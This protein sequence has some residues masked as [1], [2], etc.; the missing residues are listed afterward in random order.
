MKGFFS[1]F[2]I[3]FTISMILTWSYLYMPQSFF[4][5]DNRLRDFMFIL[6]GEIPQS[7]NVV[8]VDIDEKSLKEFGQWPW[9]RDIFSKLLYNLT[10]AG[11]GIIGLDIVFAEKDRTSP[12]RYAKQFPDL[13]S[14]LPNYDK[15]LGECL[16]QTPVIGGYIFSF[17]KDVKEKDMVEPP[18]IPAI[19]I[20]KGLI[21]NNT[22]LVPSNVIL[23]VDV[24]Q[25]GFFSTGF[26]NTIP[27]E[28][29]MI[30]SVPL[31]MMYDGLVYPSLTLEML[32]A[33]SGIRKVKV[34][35][36]DAGIRSI[37]FG[38]YSIPTDKVGRIIVNYRGKG[39]T[40]KY[41]AAQKILNN[42]FNPEDI[43]G[44]YILIGTS[45][46]GLFDLRSM[47]FDSAYAGVEV[48][49]NVIDNVLTGDYLKKP[50]D[51]IVYDIIIIWI[52]TFFFLMV[53]SVINSWWII[54]TGLIAVYALFEF[55]FH[56]LFTY[57][58]VLNLLLPLVSYSVTLII[59]IGI[60]YVI[61]TR[62]KEQAKKMLGKKVSPAVM[63][64][65]LKH[66]ADDLVASR[67][68][69]A[70]IFFSDIRSFTSISEKIGS[71]DKLIAMLNT[72]MT[73]M[74]ESI[75][76]AQGTIDKFIGDAIMA[77]WNA[78]IPVENHTDKAL[79]SAV[80][81]IEMLV[82]INKIVTPEYDVT[83]D[84]GIGIHTGNVTAGDMGAE[85]RSDYTIIGDNVNLAS[86]LEGLT[87]QYGAQILISA[88]AKSR[89]KDDYK[90]RKM[91]LVEVK[92]KNEAVEIFEVICN[93]K[94]IDEKELQDYDKAI[95][96]FRNAEVNLASETFNALQEKYP[97]KLYAFYQERC[98]Y[99]ID[100]PDLEFTPVL[101]MTTK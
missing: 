82:D 63:D 18:A 93:N 97:S 75:I 2:A 5:I 41:I 29:G 32:R 37:E 76:E 67:E 62:Q 48:H 36:D 3:A 95:T 38:E 87:K 8:I 72:Y 49:A 25:E 4:S 81:Q 94:N 23:N 80:K 78:P 51:I 44:K 58:L 101:K 70:T 13:A 26:F 69:E 65:L 40:F 39:R 60:D 68:V 61:A 59:A 47:P 92:G 14:R 73:P 89:L 88:E 86:R 83:I 16:A 24:L 91:D 74:V 22:I 46:V 45:A 19:F 27:D 31:V 30:R 53:F 85:G 43:A 20:Q 21:N 12:H 64:Y 15:L 10:D 57:G 35:G 98:K 11:A 96:L 71:P 55:F 50:A 56:M 84:I 42:E 28:S 34:I 17:D 54:P 52:I 7:D 66:S 33:A 100:N 79:N 9:Q 90:I 6:R 99:F 1:K 77:Y